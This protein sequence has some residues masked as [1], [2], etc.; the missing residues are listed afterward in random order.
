MAAFSL[1]FDSFPFNNYGLGSNKP[2]SLLFIGIF[3]IFNFTKLRKISLFKSDYIFMLFSILI[4]ALSLIK[5]SFYYENIEGFLVFINSFFGFII[6]TLSIIVYL[7]NMDSVSNLKI[8]KSIMFGY[9]VSL[10]FGI[11]EL[12]YFI[13]KIEG[14]GFIL[15]FFLRDGNYLSNQ[16]VQFA[17]GE[18]SYIGFHMYLVLIPAY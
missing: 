18:P 14:I 13:F 5:V 1:P 8:L 4:L 9:L 16:R 7:N 6:I 11:M 15:S 2:L 12:V 17:F 3:L 10:F